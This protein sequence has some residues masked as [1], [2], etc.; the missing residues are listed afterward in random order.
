MKTIIIDN[1]TDGIAPK[2]RLGGMR[3]ANGSPAYPFGS[4]QGV[5]PFRILGLAMVG[6][7]SS[8]IS[9][10]T[11]TGLPIAVVSDG[12][13]FWWLDQAGAIYKQTSGDTVTKDHTSANPEGYGM[14]I[15]HDGTAKYL[16]WRSDQEIGRFDLSATYSDNYITGLNA[17]AGT[18][19]PREVPIWSYIGNLYFG[20]GN[21]IGRKVAGGT[22]NKTFLQLPA[23]YEAKQALIYGETIV[24]NC[25]NRAENAP[26]KL[27]F[28][29]GIKADY[30][31]EIEIT[32]AHSLTIF[33]KD[34]LIYGLIGGIRPQIGVLSGRNF[35]RL[36]SVQSYV[37]TDSS[38]GIST[39]GFALPDG[40]SVVDV[41]G[42]TYFGRNP[43][44]DIYGFG[45]S[46]PGLD[47]SLNKPIFLGGSTLSGGFGA[48]TAKAA[49]SALYY[50]Y[51]TDDGTAYK[52]ATA[53]FGS[54]TTTAVEFTTPVLDMGSRRKKEIKQIRIY[55]L[56]HQ[57]GNSI[58]VSGKKNG[59]SYTSLFTTSFA[60][61]GA[62]DYKAY[63][64]NKGSIG[65]DFEFKVS[66]TSANGNDLGIYK[67][68]IDWD[69]ASE[70]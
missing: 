55:F 41:E 61:D 15:H 53:G 47:Y 52:I 6:R 64:W 11:V 69:Y 49:N 44:L 2:P 42:V 48:M 35:K 43:A 59:G 28:W 1:W 31:E 51:Q 63:N 36:R 4:A 24:L 46:Q 30:Q 40:C 22:E 27:V 20:N 32:G 34:N 25:F 12:S 3:D 29:D 17:V 62:K 56:T 10:T 67:I 50:A 14:C 8:I 58:T 65:R 60:A 7:S 26:A 39:Q 45:T 70:K 38:V 21:Y 37:S 23:N 66:M 19:T 33:N 18:T 54:Y 57:A 5:D 9:G 13:Q 16:Y 68:E